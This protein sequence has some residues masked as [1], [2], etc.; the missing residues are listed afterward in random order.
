MEALETIRRI[1]VRAAARNREGG[2]AERRD[3]AQTL[4]KSRAAQGENFRVIPA[5]VGEALFP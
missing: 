3:H 4:P 1:G 5:L 2:M